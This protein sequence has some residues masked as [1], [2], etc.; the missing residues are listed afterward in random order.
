MEAST[1]NRI[2]F[3]GHPLMLAGVR[4]HSARNAHEVKH[5]L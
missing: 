1:V 3:Y 4:T 2:R 5:G